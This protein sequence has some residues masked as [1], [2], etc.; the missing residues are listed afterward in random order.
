VPRTAIE[1]FGAEWT[2]PENIVSNGAFVLA[3]WVPRQSITLIKNPYYHAA[4]SVKLDKIIFYPTEDTPEE[5]RRFEAGELHITYH[6]PADK[7]EAA[8][9]QM[10]GRFKNYPSLGT[11]YYVVN[12]DRKPLGTSSS[13]REALALAIDRETLVEKITKGG[14]VPAYSYVPNVLF[15][16]TPSY[17]PFKGMPTDQRIERAKELLK[18]AGY[19]PD[20]PLSFELIYNSDRHG[21]H[22]NIAL[23]IQRMWKAVGVDA[24]LTGAERAGYYERLMRHEYDVGRAGWIA[25]FSDPINFL[26]Q[27]TSENQ[28]ANYPHFH[29]SEYDKL[30][31][32]SR[33][34]L[35]PAA[36]MILLSEAEQLIMNEVV[37]I[38]LFHDAS[39]HMVSPRLVGWK[40]NG[41]DVHL[42]RY[43]SLSQ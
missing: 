20:N 8:R 22:K 3:D 33:K 29:N 31:G 34:A 42:G 11:Y 41:R 7:I 39:N 32:D 21:E 12:F 1:K 24:K 27:F 40:D 36:R 26:E 30:I 38:P 28:S 10:A 37:I 13:L 17:L 16:Y 15:G 43:L 18:A 35:A 2:K 6:V 9:S 4:D 23:A 14:E 5:F 19:T 25:D